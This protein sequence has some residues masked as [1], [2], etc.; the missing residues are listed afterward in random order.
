[1]TESDQ[2]TGCGE[3]TERGEK[4][5]HGGQVETGDSGFLREAPALPG[6]SRIFYNIITP[7]QNMGEHMIA[8]HFSWLNYIYKLAAIISSA[9]PVMK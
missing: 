7:S 4:A 1:M 2:E 8:T 5:G 3:K 6:Q 9:H